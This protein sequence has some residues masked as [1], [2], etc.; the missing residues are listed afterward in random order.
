M[1]R[2]AH[3]QNGSS[4]WPPP[5]P[6]GRSSRYRPAA[7]PPTAEGAEPAGPTRRRRS[8]RWRA[9]YSRPRSALSFFLAVGACLASWRAGCE[10]R[11]NNCL[12]SEERWVNIQRIHTYPL[13]VIKNCHKNFALANGRRLIEDFV[14]VPGCSLGGRRCPHAHQACLLCLV[15]LGFD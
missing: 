9:R 2:C 11:C 3:N 15:R 7:A 6:R 13:S 4:K 8:R 12:D 1:K 14:Y 10:A 5:P